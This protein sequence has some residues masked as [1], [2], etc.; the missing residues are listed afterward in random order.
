MDNTTLT[1]K[2]RLTVYK[3][4]LVLIKRGEK[5][6][7]C[8]AIYAACTTFG[9]KY[10]PFGLKM[11]IMNDFP[12]LQQYK[13]PMLISA[14]W[15]P[16]TSEGRKTRISILEQIIE[17]LSSNQIVFTPKLD[18]N[19]QHV[20]DYL[21][22]GDYFYDKDKE[23][24]TKWHLKWVSP[25]KFFIYQ[26]KVVEGQYDNLLTEEPKQPEGFKFKSYS[27]Y[28]CKSY[29]KYIRDEFNSLADWCDEQCEKDLVLYSEVNVD[30]GNNK[31]HVSA[32]IFTYHQGLKFNSENSARLFISELSKIENVKYYD[33]FI[34]LAKNTR[35]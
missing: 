26:L 14:F 15:F 3:E 8:D 29:E 28:G 6:C 27:D 32:Y 20:L 34:N 2:E 10:L 31:L 22:Q 12:E 9:G 33:Y 4:M 5:A 18:T 13:P 30:S 1:Q 17:R 23:K 11:D 24:Y 35:L 19:G 21:K 16:T 25:S 7:F